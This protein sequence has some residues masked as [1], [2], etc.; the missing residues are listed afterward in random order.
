[1]AV[2][3]IERANSV[4]REDIKTALAAT[5]D[6]KGATGI[7]TLDANGDATKTAIIKKVADGKFVYETKVEPK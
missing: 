7:I 6:F 3:A 5:K 2:D 1:L 4:D